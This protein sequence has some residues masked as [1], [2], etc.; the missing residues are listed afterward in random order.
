MIVSAQARRSLGQKVSRASAMC[1]VRMSKALLGCVKAGTDMEGAMLPLEQANMQ[2]SPVH[3]LL[4]EAFHVIPILHLQ[5]SI[6]IGGVQLSGT[7]N[8]L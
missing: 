5:A 6:V 8:Q 2:G 3:S 4:P 1:C 7:A